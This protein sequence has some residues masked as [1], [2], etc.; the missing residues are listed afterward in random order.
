MPDDLER[1]GKLI[2]VVHRLRSPGGCPWD[3]EQT[4]GSLRSTLLEEAYEVLEAIDEQEVGK[5]RDELGDVLLQVLMQA[6]IAHESSE[7]T[8]GDVA[9]A[10]REKLVRRHPHV[11][12]TTQVSGAEEVLRNWDALKATEYGRISA[13]D[14]V[15]RSLPA[16]QWA[17]SLQ[18]R[19]ANVGFDWP[20]VD[21]ALDKVREELEE[22]RQ[23]ATPE[24]REAEF[25]DLLFTMVNVARKLGMNP[26]D[27]L[28]HATARF[29]A[30]FR[31]MEAATRADGRVL[32]ELPA[33][34]LD[35]YWEAAKRGG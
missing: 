30:R 17:W 8:L 33:E 25:G 6:E 19:A 4:H 1:L 23:A 21:G 32:S 11:F 31:L 28:R 22:L 5:L 24:E 14:G 7:F 10:V 2:E 26:E 9:D 34:E 13:L 3:R 29:E 12:G 35:R 27:A 20:E 18:R 16:L 15:Q